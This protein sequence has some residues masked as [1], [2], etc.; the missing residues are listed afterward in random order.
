MIKRFCTI[1][2]VLCTTL[3]VLSCKKEG[4]TTPISDVGNIKLFNRN[5]YFPI[6]ENMTWTYNNGITVRTI[7]VDTIKNTFQILDVDSVGWFNGVVDRDSKGIFITHNGGAIGPWFMFLDDQGIKRFFYEDSKISV[8]FNWTDNGSNTD[9]ITS[10]V[11][12]YSTTCT[13]VSLSSTITTHGGQSYTNCVLLRKQSTWSNGKNDSS[14]Y[15]TEAFY[16][17]K[18]GIG[19][20]AA[21]RLWSDGSRDTSYVTSYNIP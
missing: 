17:I 19:Y 9:P 2:L 3:T 5:S 18:K 6:I 13:V 15:L 21:A 8:G 20:V 11:Y 16:Y 4:T 7:R 14:P 1:L 12:P 10:V